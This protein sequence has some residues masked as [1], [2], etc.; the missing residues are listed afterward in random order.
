MLSV[1]FNR[2]YH[3]LVALFGLWKGSQYVDTDIF[4]EASMEE[5]FSL[6]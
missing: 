5:Q 1:M 2:Y 3:E 6:W 4:Q